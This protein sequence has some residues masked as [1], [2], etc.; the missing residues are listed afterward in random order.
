MKKEQ[1]VIRVVVVSQYFKESA[2]QML[3][4]NIV[5]VIFIF[6]ALNPCIMFSLNSEI[7]AMYNTQLFN[8]RVA[9][10]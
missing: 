6:H 1:R 2:K 7:G 5:S 4:V 3:L 8:S 9:V 10:C